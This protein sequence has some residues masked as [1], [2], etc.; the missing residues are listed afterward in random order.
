M[1]AVLTQID[2]RLVLAW[3]AALVLVLSAPILLPRHA[4]LGPKDAFADAE[5]VELVA[6]S[7]RVNHTGPYR[8]CAIYARER[9]GLALSGAA[10]NWW[11]Q[12][13]GLYRRS[14]APETGAV[15]VMGGTRAGHVG[16]VAAVLDERNILIDH[17]NW[18]EHGE[19]VTA[20]LVRDVSPANDW[21]AVRVWHPPTRTLGL[22]RYPVYG[23]I[24]PNEPQI[25][26]A[27][28]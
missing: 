10:R 13:A 4:A 1:M 3:A 27:A 9:S 5:T 14:H 8:Q 21:S 11:A 12:A 16:V 19:I 2:R 26:A 20:A 22:A 17:A 18:L 25:E 15:I 28:R 23:F 24:H 6:F 7:A